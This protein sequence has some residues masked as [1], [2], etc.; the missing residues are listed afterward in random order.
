MLCGACWQETNDEARCSACGQT[1]LLDGRYRLDARLGQGAAGIAFA[2]TRVS[3][4]A[5]VCIKG[6]AFRGMSSFEAER[7]FHREAAVLKQI[8][9]PQVPAYIDDFALGQGPSFTLYLVQ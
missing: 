2:A 6:L 8:R 3:D 7:L 4:G 1:P 5:R 9:H